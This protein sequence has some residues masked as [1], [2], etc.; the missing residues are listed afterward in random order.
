MLES[1]ITN[2]VPTRAE[3]SDVENAVFDGTDAVMLSGEAATGAFPI[4]A[5]RFLASCTLA[6]EQKQ[7]RLHAFA[8]R[9]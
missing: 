8:S 7:M 5:V 3:V 2:P 4:E 9:F 1:M 6:A